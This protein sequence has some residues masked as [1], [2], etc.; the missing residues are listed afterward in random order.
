MSDKMLPCCGV[1]M[2]EDPTSLKYFQWTPSSILDR[3]TSCSGPLSKKN[4]ILRKNSD[5]TLF[6]KRN[7]S[8]NR[9]RGVVKSELDWTLWAVRIF[10]SADLSLSPKWKN[11]DDDLNLRGDGLGAWHRRLPR[12]SMNRRWRSIP[13]RRSC[14]RGPSSSRMQSR[15]NPLP[16]APAVD[17]WP[18]IA[19]HGGIRGSMFEFRRM[20][21]SMVNARDSR[22]ILVQALDRGSS[23][24][25]M[26][27]QC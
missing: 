8:L 7:L 4:L 11:P 10:R 13:S 12:R 19:C 17:V 3:L 5:K 1:R 23:N 18:P 15:R 24:S 16:G 27:S 9:M 26:S 22:F 25:P 14:C 6:R 21:N 20:Q 2:E